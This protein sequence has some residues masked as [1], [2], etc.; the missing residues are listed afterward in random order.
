MKAQ[1]RAGE[2]G[3]NYLFTLPPVETIRLADLVSDCGGVD[4]V[5]ER[6]GLTTAL[7][8]LWVSG[9]VIAPKYF[10]IA[11]WWQSYRGFDQA[12]AETHYANSRNYRELC[13]AEARVELL[14]Q[15]VHRALERL[16]DDGR[17]LK[18]IAFTGQ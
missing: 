18:S 8:K 13:K 14:E 4:L 11:L 3:H 7:L 5:A 15:V 16:G 12:F 10:L 6:F 2:T 9:E 17:Y 1:K